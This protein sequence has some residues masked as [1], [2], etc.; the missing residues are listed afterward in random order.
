MK[1]FYIFNL[2]TGWSIE[3]ELRDASEIALDLEW[4]ATYGKT[5]YL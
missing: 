4:S 2:Q 3:K 5:L 1:E